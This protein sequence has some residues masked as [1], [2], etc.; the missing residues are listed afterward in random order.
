MMRNTNSMAWFPRKDKPLNAE[1]VKI[2][3]SAAQWT[4]QSMD[5]R[6]PKKSLLIDRNFVV[7]IVFSIRCNSVAITNICNNVAKSKS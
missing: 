2:K 5:A 4:A 6:K 3:G 1:T 7:F